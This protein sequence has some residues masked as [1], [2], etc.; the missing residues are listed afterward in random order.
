MSSLFKTMA[1]ADI[2]LEGTLRLLSLPD[3]GTDAEAGEEIVAL[4]GRYGPIS[5]G[6]TRSLATEDELFTVTVQDALRLFAEPKRRGRACGAPA[7][8]GD[9]PCRAGR[10]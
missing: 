2:T 6:R 4:N 1:P 7:G 8:A 5:R 3:G 10:W 9:D